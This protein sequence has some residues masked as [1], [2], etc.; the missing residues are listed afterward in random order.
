MRRGEGA[1]A[2]EKE[3]N[4]APPSQGSHT[5]PWQ[6]APAMPSWE[7]S[8]FPHPLQPVQPKNDRGGEESRAPQRSIAALWHCSTLSNRGA[9]CRL[10]L[11]FWCS[12]P[13]KTQKVLVAHPPA[14]VLPYLLRLARLVAT[15]RSHS[16]LWDYEPP[17]ASSHLTA[18]TMEDPIPGSPTPHGM[19]G[20]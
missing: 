1:W 13:G 7:Q 19:G 10:L 16:T 5:Q 3:Q 20:N 14:L 18:S 15:M 2:S 6:A 17:P 4:T 9:R 8:F 12:V 11:V